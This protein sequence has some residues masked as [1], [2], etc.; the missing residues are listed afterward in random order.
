MATIDE[1]KQQAEAVK[2]ATQVGEN[3]AERVGGALA[4]LA[5]IAKAQE[6]NIGKKAD[7]EEMNRLL[8][9]KAN[10]ADVDTKFTEE[11]KRVD[12]ELE[13]KANDEEVKRSFLEQT[14]K[15][16][17][18]DAEIAKKANSEDVTSQMQTEQTRVN[19]ELAKKFNKEDIA[20][21][22]GDSKDKV[23]SQHALPF[24]YIQ[25]EEFIFAMV[26]A[27]DVFLA[28]IRWDGTPKYAKIEENTNREIESINA[29]IKYI[30]EQI[31]DARKDLKRNVLSL[32]FD[33]STGR[34]IGTTS[35]T[36]RITSCTQDRTT[37]KIIMNHQLD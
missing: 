22:F 32:S 4:G 17:A 16:T 11:K 13:K 29:Q 21:D 7:K 26:D 8:A 2:N 36:S 24:R 35:D 1:I 6:D 28:G 27:N 25:N 5:D 19:D 34:I 30:H 12:A 3:T 31:S 9:T 15:N 20:Q 18:Q 23:V 37:G 14:A 10:T 33:R